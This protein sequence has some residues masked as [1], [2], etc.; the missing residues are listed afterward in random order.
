[1]HVFTAQVRGGVI[2]PD[3]GITLREGSIVTVLFDDGER[4]FEVTP[5]E[6]RELLEAIAGADRGEVISADE[7]LKRLRR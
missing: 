3:E 1:M 4:E 6:E 7:L 2:V 5:E